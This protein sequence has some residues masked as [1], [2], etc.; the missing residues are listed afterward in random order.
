MGA[1]GSTAKA[2]MKRMQERIEQLEE[3]KDQLE[4]DLEIA[5]GVRLPWQVLAELR[6]HTGFANWS[7]NKEG[8]GTLEDHRDPSQCAGVTVNNSGE[9]TKIDL[10]MRN[11]AGGK[12]PAPPH[13]TIC[14]A[15]T[16]S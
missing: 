11:L 3:R 10:G 16:T 12:P 2:E 14:L 15:R 5:K 13:L 4:K 6:D 1:G 7:K 8:W 9:I